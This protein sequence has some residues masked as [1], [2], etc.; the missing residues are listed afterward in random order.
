ML[1][2]STRANPSAPVDVLSDYDVIVV[3][4][5]ITP[6]LEDD[7]WLDDLGKVLVVYR[8]PIR[9]DY[10][11]EKFARITQYED[12]TKIDYTVWPVELLGRVVEDLELPEYLDVGYVVLVDKDQLTSR[13]K[14]PTYTAY[15][16]ISPT[17][18]QYRALVEEFLSE[19][20][21]VA[22]NLWRDEL[23]FAKYSL[24]HVMKFRLLRRMLEWQ[25]G[26]HHNWSVPT[27]AYGKGLKKLV[28]PRVWSQLESTYV[29]AEEEQ[30]WEALFGAI[31]LFQEV[32][33][34]VGDHLG[35][36]YPDDQHQ[37]V[38]RYLQRVKSLDRQAECFS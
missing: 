15:I 23:V 29:G 1:L 22:K 5:D 25:I 16:P 3:V 12:G 10:G 28:S 34:E 35:Y 20:P 13:L 9:L 11:I 31:A 26:I 38:V 24:D 18:E 7:G 6:F 21:Y 30:N 36:A 17:E 33:V 27:G 14:P 2:T 8:D 4:E 37:R 32:A 19:T